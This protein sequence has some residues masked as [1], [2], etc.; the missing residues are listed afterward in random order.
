MNGFGFKLEIPMNPYTG[1]GFYPN[2]L[3]NGVLAVTLGK[4]DNEL[5]FHPQFGLIPKALIPQIA[6][7]YVPGL[8]IPININ[9]NRNITQP[10]P[11]VNNTNNNTV[12]INKTRVPYEIIGGKKYI[13]QDGNYFEIFDKMVKIDNKECK[14]IKID[15]NHYLSF[16]NQLVKIFDDKIIINGKKYTITI[17]DGKKYLESD[18]CLYLIEEAH[19]IEKG[20]KTYVYL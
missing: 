9:Q 4:H 11:Q 8:G 14:F 3:N 13:S 17:K 19:I 20:V 18:E 12:I 6:V 16:D 5:I 10:Q 1:P 15:G 2:G 7:P